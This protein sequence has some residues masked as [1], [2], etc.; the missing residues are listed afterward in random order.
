MSSSCRGSGPD[1]HPPFSLSFLFSFVFVLFLLFLLFF[2]FR[3][4]DGIV[5]DS[6]SRVIVIGATNRPYNL[7]AAI[8]RRMPLQFLFD[9]PNKAQRAQ[10]LNV[11]RTCA[12]ASRVVCLL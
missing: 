10:I 5:T 3:L 7:S 4:W 6:K 8:L 12:R 2:A 1:R 11:V 9:L